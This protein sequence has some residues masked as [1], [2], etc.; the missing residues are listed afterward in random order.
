MPRSQFEKRLRK[1]KAQIDPMETP[2]KTWVVVIK[3]VAV[4]PDTP[5]AEISWSRR[6]VRT[7]D[8]RTKVS[9]PAP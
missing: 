8:L 6:G 5:Y 9:D 4:R 7:V 2:T 3:G 1:L